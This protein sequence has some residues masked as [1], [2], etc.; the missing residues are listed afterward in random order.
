MDHIGLME[1]IIDEGES[2]KCRPCELP[3]KMW[4]H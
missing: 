4:G 1:L 2:G 3:N